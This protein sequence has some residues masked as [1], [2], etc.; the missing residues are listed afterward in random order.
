MLTGRAATLPQ[1]TA[2]AFEQTS[3]DQQ[4]VEDVQQ[5]TNHA[6]RRGTALMH[7]S[8]NAL[9]LAA[10]TRNVARGGSAVQ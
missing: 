7:V 2:H 10:G 4:W 6:T 8:R 3:I 1:T 5:A 9:T